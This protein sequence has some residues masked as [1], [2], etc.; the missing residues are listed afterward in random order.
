MGSLSEE[1]LQL[2]YTWVD[3]I[4][5]SR[6]KK[7]IARDFSDGVLMAEIVKHFFPKLVQ[8]HNYSSASSQ[9][10]KLYNWNTLNQ[11]IFKKIDFHVDQKQIEDVVNCVPYAIENLLKSFQAKVTQIQEKKIAKNNSREQSFESYGEQHAAEARVE[12][13]KKEKSV[14]QNKEK[15]Q[16]VPVHN[17]QRQKSHHEPAIENTY[18]EE[19]IADKDMKIAELTETVKLLESKVSKL[20][21]LIR[22]KDSKIHAL[23]QK[24]KDGDH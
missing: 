10:Q 23:T 5:L 8:L 13:Q 1:E 20:N 7:N 12:I 19:I 21:L 3:A 17:N 6:P 4:P 11:K 16:Q 24:L 22:L 14:I 15:N 9:R 2:L 18:Y